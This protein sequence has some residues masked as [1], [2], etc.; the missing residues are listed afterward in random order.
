MAPT[1]DTRMI[2]T[3]QNLGNLPTAKLCGPRKLRFFEKTRRTEALRNR[4]GRVAHCAFPK[5][6]NRLDHNTGGD[7][8][9]AEDDVANA[10]LTIHKVLSD[11]VIY[12]FI[13]PAKQAESVSS[14]KLVSH[15]L[16][17]GFPARPEQEERT[18]GVCG[19]DG[20]EDRLSLHDHSCSSSEWR[21]VDGAVDVGRL[22]ANVVAAE[23]EQTALP[24]LSE[25]AFGAETVDEARKQRKDIDSERRHAS[26]AVMNRDRTGHLA[27]PP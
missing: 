2:S 10:D 16:I 22:I 8:S 17:E 25:Q 9:P 24:G 6:R 5:A 19:C 26:R 4:A 12:S 18:H 1:F 21:I 27:C 11:S 13:A 23:V 3:A 15:R 20:L 14:R 7:L